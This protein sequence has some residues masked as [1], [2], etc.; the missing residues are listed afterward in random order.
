M[1][2]PLRVAV[3]PGDPAIRALLHG[4]LTD[5][6]LQVSDEPVGADVVL[7]R[8]GADLAPGTHLILLAAPAEAGAALDVMLATPADRV[9]HVVRWP[10][11]D[12]ERTAT[13]R[14]EL[15]PALV[16]LAAGRE[17]LAW[18]TPLPGPIEPAP[19]SETPFTVVAIG[20]GRGGLPALRQLLTAL[21]P[22]LPA[23]V[24]V[25]QHLPAGFH[26]LLA[27]RLAGQQRS[28]GVR[29]LDDS[30]DGLFRSAARRHGAG[31]LA[32]VLGGLG[33]DGVQ[34]ATVVR[35]AGGTVL[36]QDEASAAPGLWGM[37]G[38]LAAAGQADR[39]V[40]LADLP[41][42]L[43][44]TLTLSLPSGP[45]RHARSDRPDLVVAG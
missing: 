18:C 17:P 13:V 23:P 43:A 42:A 10:K 6:R 32:V 38:A 5:P 21:P 14:A 20:A 26:R 9:A 16:G 36:G 22:D 15:L 35:A 41:A 39:L 31:V 8:P 25:A 27:D 7:A 33:R 24:V 12:V 40:P 45:G 4:G 34:G 37:P 29:V 2:R 28:G 30:V 44:V 11:G 1:S 19:R 3:A